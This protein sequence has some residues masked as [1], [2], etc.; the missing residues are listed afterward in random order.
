[1]FHDVIHVPKSRLPCFMDMNLAAVRGKSLPR[2]VL[3]QHDANDSMSP[4][5]LL[6]AYAEEIRGILLGPQ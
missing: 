2:V 6:I 5:G 4:L 1:M 3:Y